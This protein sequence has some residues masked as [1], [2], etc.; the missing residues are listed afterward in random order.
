MSKVI[1]TVL[2]AAFVF[3]GTCVGGVFFW[4]AFG[5]ASAA[6]AADEFLA[7]V[8]DHKMRLAYAATASEFRA[9]QD[10]P[11]FTS[12]VER[13]EIKGYEFE[14]WRDRKLP[15]NGRMMISGILDAHNG[16]TVPFSIVTLKEAD[17]WRILSFTG[18]A[19]FGTG[20]GAWF[21][22]IP[23]PG[24]LHRLVHDAMVGFASAIMERDLV[25]YYRSLSTALRSRTP[26]SA[27][28]AKFQHFIDDETDFSGI[29][30]RR[31]ILNDQPRIEN[32]EFGEVLIVSGCY[33]V[34]P[35]PAYFTL[36]YVYRHPEWEPFSVQIEMADSDVLCTP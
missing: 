13:V 34:E 5:T 32:R 7:S 16:R 31:A 36:M 2:V 23:P 25:P 4:V 9:E 17:E 26:L 14:H 24:E 27:F 19:R 11:T 30:E 1:L 12:I 20:P 22:Q 28:E 21:R 8:T 18:P 35:F 29:E 3:I 15:Y 6:E 33:T 10:L